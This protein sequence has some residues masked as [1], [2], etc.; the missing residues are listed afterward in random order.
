MRGTMLS[1]GTH[2]LRR[3]GVGLAVLSLVVVGVQTAP[4]AAATGGTY[5]VTAY[6]AKADGVTDATAGITAAIAAAQ[7]NG[8][9]TVYFPAGT[10]ALT[11]VGHIGAA[12]LQVHGSVPV[13]LLGGGRDVTKLVEHVRNKPLLS[14][15]VDNT[16]IDGLTLDT[17]TY[18]GRGSIGVQA[19]NTLFQRSRVIGGD[20][21]FAVFYMGPAGASPSNPTYNTGNRVIDISVDDQIMNDGFSFSYQD[22]GLIQNVTHHGSRLAVYKDKNVLVDGYYYTTGIQAPHATDGFYVTPPAANIVINNFVT[23]GAGGKVGADQPTMSTN[24]VISGERMLAAGGYHLEIGNVTGLTIDGAVFNGT[25]TLKFWPSASVTGAVVSN[26]TISHIS[27][28]QP[29]TASVNASFVND[30]YGPFMAPNGK[31]RPTFQTA[32]GGATTFSVQDGTWTNR[33]GGFMAGV[34]TTYT[35]NGLVGYP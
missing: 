22:H 5:D 11:S 27:F 30:T 1:W 8:G 13:T 7:L 26:S 10:F 23:D 21:W 33:A 14:V 18:D 15:R 25:N 6:G 29:A 32:Q 2:G 9:G 28:A 16:V 24:I 20:L 34:N 4:A 19:N 12:S 17:Q 3:A 35:V 31:P